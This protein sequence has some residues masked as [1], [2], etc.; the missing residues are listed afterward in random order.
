MVVCSLN[1]SA[2]S[3]S[4][5]PLCEGMDA[6]RRW[7]KIPLTFCKVIFPVLQF[8]VIYIVCLIYL[9]IE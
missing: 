6:Q 5:K 9:L 4:M 7:L 1:H 3:P 2:Y 8:F